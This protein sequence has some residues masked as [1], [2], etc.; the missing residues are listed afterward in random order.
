MYKAVRKPGV[1]CDQVATTDWGFCSK[2]SRTVQAKRAK[3]AYDLEHAEQEEPV[4]PPLEEE[5]VEQV[6]V[7]KPKVVV[8]K[9]KQPSSE[10]KKSKAV[11][12]QKPAKKA[13]TLKAE[14]KRVQ[15][16]IVDSETVKPSR[17][18]G[19]KSKTSVIDKGGKKAVKRTIRRNYWGNFEDSETG[20]VFNAE[21]KCAIGV[22]HKSG[23]ILPLGDV[24]IELCKRFRWKYTVPKR[25]TVVPTFSSSSEEESEE[26]SEAE[27]ISEPEE[28]DEELEESEPEEEEETSDLEDEEEEEETSD[29]E[30]DEELDDEDEELVEEGSDYDW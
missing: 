23:R 28:E 20:I 13:S 25:M 8:K 17:S 5:V 26:E 16:Q 10:A 1:D 9:P 14:T 15:T 12:K 2:H 4:Q 6:P 27:E 21:E 19:A 18:T 30:E 11:V 3:D 22:Q 24:H 7:S 29:L